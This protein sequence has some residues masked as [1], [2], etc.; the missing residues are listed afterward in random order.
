[1]PVN[2]FRGA[3]AQDPSAVHDEDPVAHGQRLVL[4]TL[5]R[6][7]RAALARGG[8]DIPEASARWLAWAR[9]V[10]GHR[11]VYALGVLAVLVALGV[12]F[13]SMR[14]GVADYSTDPTSTTTTTYRGYEMLV[15]GF[16]PGFSGPLQ[17]VAPVT[18]PADRAEFA[19]VVRAA[20][21]A[22]GVVA[23]AGP[24]VLPAAPAIRPSR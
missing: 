9:R 20:A 16:G 4:R 18:G 14:Q 15:Q 23:T 11:V 6:R 17:L 13:F 3:L 2:L 24:E 1:L 8:T 7:Q 5:T 22:P 10:E 19:T 21:H 12:P